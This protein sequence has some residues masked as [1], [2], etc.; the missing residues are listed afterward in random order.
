MKII[1]CIMTCLSVGRLCTPAWWPSSWQHSHSPNQQV[2]TWLPRW[3][4]KALQTVAELQP[5]HIIIFHVVI[6]RKL[7]QSNVTKPPTSG[8]IITLS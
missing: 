1:V 7:H 6:H 4:F 8:P 3:G 5:L 2:N